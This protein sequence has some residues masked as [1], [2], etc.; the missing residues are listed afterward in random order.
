MWCYKQLVSLK[1]TTISNRFFGCS[2]L[3][4][5]KTKPRHNDPVPD[6]VTV[7]LLNRKQRRQNTSFELKTQKKSVYLTV[8]PC[9]LPLFESYSLYYCCKNNVKHLYW[10]SWTKI[11]TCVSYSSSRKKCTKREY[12]LSSCG[13]LEKIWFDLPLEKKNETIYADHYFGQMF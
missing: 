8:N 3:R 10:I 2:W 5:A 13:K 4:K 1:W 6:W 11:V 9:A 7:T 12:T